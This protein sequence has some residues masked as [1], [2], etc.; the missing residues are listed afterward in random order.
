VNTPALAV[1]PLAMVRHE[2]ARLTH[3]IS[4]QAS[5]G[6]TLREQ[7]EGVEPL[8]VIVTA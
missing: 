5:M 7:M 8:M 3:V 1:A 6:G 2:A 4:R